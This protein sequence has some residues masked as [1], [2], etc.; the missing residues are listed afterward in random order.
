MGENTIIIQKA[1][2]SDNLDGELPIK[3]YK[4]AK[5][6]NFKKLPVTANGGVGG[7]KRFYKCAREIVI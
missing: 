5:L 2:C 6:L 3:P 4:S 7:G 1:G